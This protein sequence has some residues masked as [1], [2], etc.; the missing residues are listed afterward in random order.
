MQFDPLSLSFDTATCTLYVAGSVDEMSAEM[1]RDALHRCLDQTTSPLTVDLTDVS[2][3]TSVGLGVLAAA[4]R[5]AAEAGSAVE[6]VAKAGS[7]AEKVLA[8][9][10]LSHTI[11]ASAASERWG[12]LDRPR[13]APPQL[14]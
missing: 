13:V 14:A 2:F 9:C 1:L 12:E 11:G 10:G 7:I 4:M 8:I 6:L 3:L 5:R